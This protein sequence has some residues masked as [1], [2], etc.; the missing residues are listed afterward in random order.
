MPGSFTSSAVSPR[1]FQVFPILS[2]DESSRLIRFGRARAFQSGEALFVAGMV[3]PGL[4]VIT[5]GIVSVWQRDSLRRSHLMACQ[6]VGEFVAEVSELSGKPALI[7]AIANTAVETFVIEPHSLRALVIEEAD[8]GERIMRALI[9]RRVA[10]LDAGMGGVVIAGRATSPSVVRLQT[11]LARNGQP[12]YQFDP[13]IE[14]RPCPFLAQ[15]EIGPQEALV[16]CM[17]GAVLRSPSEAELARHLGMIDTLERQEIYDCAIVGAGPA[18]LATAVY[19]ASE[20]LRVIVVDSRSYGGQAGASARIENYL[21]FPT[22][23]SGAALASR[24]FVQAQKFGAEIVIPARV[25]S[26]H[27]SNSGEGHLLSLTLA[28]GRL[29]RSRTAVLATGARYR[30]PMVPHL[31]D[32]EGRGVWYWASPIE[33]RICGQQH[34]ALAGA[35]NSAGQAAVYLSAHV[36]HIAMLVRARSLEGSMS[37]YLIDRIAACS[38]IELLTSCEILS[39][40]GQPDTGLESVTWVH[41]RTN[42]NETRALRN[43]FLFIGADPEVDC[44]GDCPVAKDNSGFILTG[45]QTAPW[46][47]AGRGRAPHALETSVPGLFAI[48]D[49]RS[50]SV[51]RVGAAIGDG[52]SVVA[53]I[54]ALLATC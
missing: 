24:A 22:G 18:G 25:A 54:H 12:H 49:V 39:L 7:D 4:V 5:S 46:Q 51:K 23:V 37:K 20:G 15:Y 38:N 33:A 52:A 17:D 21:G 35:G 29:I 2:R 6:G 41:S 43:L 16:V 34:V 42:L 31:C 10:L 47:T 48:G 3:G 1:Q 50:G 27:E 14:Q 44:I 45:E 26:L 11:F 9:L 19:A 30:R 32:F 13:A 40:D 28:D 53:Q 36:K 8:L